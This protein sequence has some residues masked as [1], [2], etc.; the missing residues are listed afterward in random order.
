MIDDKALDTDTTF[1]V[2]CVD[3][4]KDQDRRLQ[5]IKVVPRWRKLGFLIQLEKKKSYGKEKN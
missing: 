1:Q 4:R 5:N 2:E 3:T